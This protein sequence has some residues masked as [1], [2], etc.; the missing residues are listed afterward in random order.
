M[1]IPES[2][3]TV[4]YTRRDVRVRAAFHTGT[5]LSS[6]AVSSNPKRSHSTSAMQ[7]ATAKTD[8]SASCSGSNRSALVVAAAHTSETAAMQTAPMSSGGMGM[9]ESPVETAEAFPIQRAPSIMAADIA[10]SPWNTCCSS[11]ATGR[12]SVS[13]AV[14]S[15]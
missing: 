14:R 2:T 9:M 12:A 1:Q 15:C 7:P 11:H 10:R 8:G 6:A 13:A 5:M 4:R 3:T